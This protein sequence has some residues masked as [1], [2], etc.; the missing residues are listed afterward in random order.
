MS[1]TVLLL[2]C[3]TVPENFGTPIRDFNPTHIILVDAAQLNLKPGSSRLVTQDR[4]VGLSISTHSLPLNVFAKY[5][6]SITHAKVILLAIQPKN[7]NFGEPLTRELDEAA[8][9]LAGIL[10]KVLDKTV[11]P[12]IR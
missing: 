9:E 6:E 5:L 1:D 12:S 11:Q 7:V 8:D 4:I 2:E 10:S 3:E